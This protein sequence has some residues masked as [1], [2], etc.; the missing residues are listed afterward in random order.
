MTG[1]AF[2]YLSFLAENDRC[3]PGSDVRTCMIILSKG[4]LTSLEERTKKCEQIR[5]AR[6]ACSK[7]CRGASLAFEILVDRS[8]STT[9][10]SQT[11]RFLLSC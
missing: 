11:Y 8:S 1:A 2:N 3:M 10:D 9:A 6:Y 4:V 7:V 5:K